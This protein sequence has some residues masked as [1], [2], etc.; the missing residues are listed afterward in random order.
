ML[1]NSTNLTLPKPQ[2]YEPLL[3]FLE[4]NISLSLAKSGKVDKG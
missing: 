2:R 3:M 1:T 4:R